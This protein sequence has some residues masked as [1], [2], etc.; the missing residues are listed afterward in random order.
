M[1]TKIG[2][3]GL[4]RMGCP[5]LTNSLRRV[6]I[7]PSQPKPGKSSSDRRRWRNY[8]RLRRRIEGRLTADHC[9]QPYS[10]HHLS[11]GVFDGL[12]NLQSL[13]LWDSNL[14]ELPPGIFDGLNNL[15]RLDL[16][17]NPGAPFRITH[18]N[19]DLRGSGWV[20]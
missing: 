17:G 10:K 5:C 8:S 20:R 12:I 14:S 16:R 13:R 6:M 2:F 3:I 4:G 11:L 1:T 15:Q 18:P 19:A 9:V 7:L